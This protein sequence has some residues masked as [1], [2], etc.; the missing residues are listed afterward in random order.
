MPVWAS[1][2]LDHGF[3]FLAKFIEKTSWT[4]SVAGRCFAERL[5]WCNGGGAAAGL[6]RANRKTVPRA[7]AAGDL[8]EGGRF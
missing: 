1:A 5:Q 8:F 3:H 6:A 7:T 2:H 4:P